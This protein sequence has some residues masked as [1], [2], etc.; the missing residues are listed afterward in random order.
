MGMK[1]K[2]IVSDD[3]CTAK[4]SKRARIEVSGDTED[5]ESWNIEIDK[6]ETSSENDQSP[7]ERVEIKVEHTDNNTSSISSISEDKQ[8]RQNESVN[9]EE[10]NEKVTETDISMSTELREKNEITLYKRN[11]NETNLNES[12]EES[13]TEEKQDRHD[14]SVEEVKANKKFTET[15]LS[16][17][18][19]LCEKTEI[20][21]NARNENEAYLNESREESVTG[22]ATAEESSSNI[23]QDQE[24]QKAKDEFIYRL[25]RFD[26]SYTDGLRPKDIY[27][28][29]CLEKHVEKGSRNGYKSRYI[30]CCKTM[31]ALRRL[32]GECRKMSYAVR[33][34]VR[35]N[36][37]KLDRNQVKV[38]DLTDYGTRKK[39][40]NESSRAWGYAYRFEEVILE[41]ITHVPKE[42]RG[43]NRKGA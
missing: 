10:A 26:E 33:E 7:N 1:R 35:I 21:L 27:S 36:I 32:G 13:E 17:T 9:E 2:G 28:S 41:P 25:L 8:D 38:I 31:N 22:E 42:M 6:S 11:E 12:R 29:I 43:E 40:I 24:S 23:E 37:T 5:E 16:M 3:S 20:T 4:E 34:V 19:E 39:H 15:E 14:D 18:T 30:S